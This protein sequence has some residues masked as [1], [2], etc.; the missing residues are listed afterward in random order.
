MKN[1]ECSEI[2]PQPWLRLS[3]NGFWDFFARGKS[4]KVSAQDLNLS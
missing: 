2:M 4:A 1:L 3:K